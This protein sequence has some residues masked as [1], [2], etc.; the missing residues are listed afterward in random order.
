MGEEARKPRPEA[1]N[2]L[3]L[4]LRRFENLNAALNG[5][6]YGMPRPCYGHD[7]TEDITE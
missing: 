6:H 2:A 4:S 7:T 3:D 1:E 5:D